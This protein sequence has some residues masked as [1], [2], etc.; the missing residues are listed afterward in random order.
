[1]IPSWDVIVIGAGPAGL[2][3][4]RG[5]AAAGRGV[6]VV[7][8]HDRIGYPVHCT[9]LVGLDAFDELSLPRE[10]IRTVL[11]RANFHGPDDGPVIVEAERIRAAVVDRGEFDSALAQQAAARGARFALATRVERI[12]VDRGGVT[13]NGRGTVLRG[14]ACVLA[15]GA[16]YRFNRAL[17][18]GVPSTLVQSAQVELPFGTASSVD[19]YLSR[20]L[21][22]DGFGWVVPFE[23]NGAS[24]ARIGL[25]CRDRAAPR[26]AS[27]ANRVWR[28][29]GLTSPLP[30]PRLKALPLGPVRRTYADRVVAVGDAAGLVKPTTGGGIYYSL[31]SGALA[32]EVLDDALGRNAL[33]EGVLR[34]YETLWRRRLGP[35]IRAGLAFRRMAS[36]LDDRAV[37]ALIDLARVDG[38]IPLLQDHGDFNWHRRAV[39]ALLRHRGFR[40]AV[41][42]SFWS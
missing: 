29:H 9:G 25:M 22:P 26:F 7:E 11:Q 6:L 30:S 13:V 37:R 5:L 41:L 33:R 24:W 18:L 17:G 31:L 8:E 28:E 16:A 32:A 3:A 12:A 35:D 42:S 34:R 21:A 19:V 27:L 2:M 38:L 15:C 1:M 4:A 36:R 23:R 39:I 10:A 14:R 20:E 40:R